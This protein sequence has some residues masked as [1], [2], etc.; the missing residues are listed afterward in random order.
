[1]RNLNSPT[2]RWNKTRLRLAGFICLF[3]LSSA[4]A[5]SGQQRQT[6]SAEDTKK[7]REDLQ[8]LAVELPK[9][10]KTSSTR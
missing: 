1:M 7:W 3:A 8:F 6:L 2:S 4:L 5:V 10:H 9:R